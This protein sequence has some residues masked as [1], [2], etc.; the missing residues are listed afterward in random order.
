MATQI[1]PS[2]RMNDRL[3]YIT[4]RWEEFEGEARANLLRAIA[5]VV[6]Y[7]VELINYQGV[8]FGFLEMPAV[9]GRPFHLAVTYL[10]VGWFMLCLGVLC[11][12]RQRIFP[13]TLK[14]IST[15]VDLLLLTSILALADGPR[16]P[17]VVGYF[18]IIAV[19][20]LRLSLPL[21]WFATG[22]AVAGY[23]VL[24]GYARW[25]CPPDRIGQMTVPRYY[26]LIF[27]LALGLSGIVLGQVIRRVRAM[28][29]AYVE[30]L[31]EGSP[32]VRP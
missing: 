9:V 4:G 19:A 1:E 12:R 2:P 17:L 21:I 3:W 13:A 8:H 26:E 15:G 20:T 29:E 23:L 27:V 10:T 7:A 25:F 24:L 30:R 11:C 28:A 18:L 6:F 5:L 16:S 22:G 32:G 31:M 14:F